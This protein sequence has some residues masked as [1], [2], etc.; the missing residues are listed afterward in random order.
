MRYSSVR[1]VSVIAILLSLWMNPCVVVAQGKKSTSNTTASKGNDRIKNLKDEQ[2]QIKKNVKQI[3]SKLNANKKNVEERLNQIE[4]LNEDIRQRSA[5]ID[6]QNV[7]LNY[8]VARIDQMNDEIL[9][10]EMDY[11]VSKR[12]YV[13]LIYHAYEKNSVYDRLLFLFSANSI[14]ESYARF[15]YIREFAKM[16]RRQASDIKDTREDLLAKR[17]ELQ[18]AKKRTEVL[19]SERETERQKIVKEKQEQKT[20]VASLRKEEKELRQKL[21]EQQATADR[22]NQRI[23]ELII[24]E[25][26][27]AAKAKRE[28]EKKKAAANQGSR[29][30]TTTKSTTG[31]SA[32][33]TA[34]NTN[35]KSNTVAKKENTP[36]QQDKP[37]SAEDAETLFFEKQKG[38]VHWPVRVGSI[39]G[40]YGLQP[41]PVLSNV[42]VNNK[43]V[44][45]TSPA[46]MEAL[47]V[48]KGK[49]TNIFSVPGANNAV[50][51][52]HGNYLT[53][54][55]NL[56]SIFVSVGQLVNQGDKLGRIYTDPDNNTKS[57]LFFQL[58][59]EKIIQNPESWLR[60]LK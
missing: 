37:L 54:Y 22:L 6:S 47:A 13:E 20:L 18:N 36:A 43:G 8:L 15:Q 55:A 10:M 19:L 59:K 49:V 33:K 1:I 5:L 40:H 23:Q 52:R 28:A 41:H 60:P 3:D 32:Q 30:A 25:A 29:S 24:A 34:V 11:N 44:Y 12:K 48:S 26:E 46:G 35:T 27:K 38:R 56:T 7:E 2:S 53:V 45:I 57:Q 51:V 14:Q 21:K 58:Y 9:G 16:R 50:V 17:Q 4:Q 42:T 39:T 31:G